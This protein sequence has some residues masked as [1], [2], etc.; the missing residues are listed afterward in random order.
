[1]PYL[2][3]YGS[4][5]SNNHNNYLLVDNNA[6]LINKLCF[7]CNSYYIVGFKNNIEN[8]CFEDG[9]SFTY[10]PTNSFK[11]PYISTHKLYDESPSIITGELYKINYKLLEILDKHEGYPFIYD[12]QYIPIKICKHIV[13][14]YVY[15]LNNTDIIN[16][17]ITNTHQYIPILTGNWKLRNIVSSAIH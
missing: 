4:L 13:Y 5:L 3:V 7:T 9:R 1:M 17:I 16:T 14:A 10:P 12:R 6:K 15:I 11:Y 2:F 8:D